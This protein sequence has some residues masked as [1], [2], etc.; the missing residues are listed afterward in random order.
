MKNQDFLEY[1]HYIFSH[2]LAIITSNTLKLDIFY[3]LYVKELSTYI[4]F[5]MGLSRF[6]E[7]H[8]GLWLCTVIQPYKPS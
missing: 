6:K 8:V 2:F 3:W 4:E 5:N 7:C 1:S